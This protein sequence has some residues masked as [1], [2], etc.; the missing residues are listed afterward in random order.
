M[1]LLTPQGC[2]LSPTLFSFCRLFFFICRLL[3]YLLFYL[4]GGDLHSLI[5]K[6]INK[7]FFFFFF[8]KL[9]GLTSTPACF[10]TSSQRKVLNSV[11]LAAGAFSL[12]PSKAAYC[13]LWSQPRTG[14]AGLLHTSL[15]E[16]RKPWLE[17]QC[18]K[19]TQQTLFPPPFSPLLTSVPSGSRVSACAKRVA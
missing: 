11:C 17:K 10:L 4:L 9:V 12:I 18:G 7:A 6:I 1:W 8:F 3:I 2:N 16:I 13:I 14:P 5:S 15:R 19:Q